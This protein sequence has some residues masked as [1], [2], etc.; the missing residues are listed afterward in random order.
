MHSNSR[1]GW[2]M[3]PVRL[4]RLKVAEELSGLSDDALAELVRR[5]LDR[6]GDSL[7]EAI[8]SLNAITH[9]AASVAERLLTGRRAEEYVL[10]HSQSVLGAPREG[11]V[12]KRLSAE[13]F[14]FGLVGRPKVAIEVK[15]LR[16]ERGDVL[17]TDREWI[18]ASARREDYWLAIVRDLSTAPWADVIV[19]PFVR[20]QA[21]C[22]YRTKITAEWRARV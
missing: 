19:N 5:V 16:A 1:K 3:R 7:E 11:L 20:I 18:E 8:S 22:A 9:V 10:E 12:D 13:G 14:D 2:R 15:G 17:F 6:D 4:S 21:T